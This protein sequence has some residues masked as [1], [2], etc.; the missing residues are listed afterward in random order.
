[1]ISP[2]AVGP[3]PGGGETYGHSLIVDPWGRILADVERNPELSS[4][5]IDLDEVRIARSKIP[6]LE[7]DRTYSMNTGNIEDDLDLEFEL[8]DYL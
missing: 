7:H 1:M 8:E 6:C 4:L 2:C 3:I 5:K